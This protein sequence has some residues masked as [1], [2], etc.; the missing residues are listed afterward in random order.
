MTLLDF[1][2]SSFEKAWNK[3]P[4]GHAMIPERVERYDSQSSL[5]YAP[6][7]YKYKELAPS[8]DD[9]PDNVWIAENFMSFVRGEFGTLHNRGEC[10]PNPKL[11]TSNSIFLNPHYKYI[12]RCENELINSDFLNTLFKDVPRDLYANLYVLLTSSLIGNKENL[13]YLGGEQLAQK[14]EPLMSQQLR[15]QFVFPGFPF[16]DQNIFRTSSDASHVDLSE[17]ASFIRLHVLA[18]AISRVYPSGADWIIISE[19]MAYASTLYVGNDEV[20]EY[21]KK[22]LSYRNALNIQNTVSI[23]D[24][25][26]MTRKIRSEEAG[27]E[28]FES[29]EKYIS[30][31]LRALISKDDQNILKTLRI[32]TRG[33]KWN[34]NIKYL[35]LSWED[36]W[37][38]LNSEF[39]DQVEERLKSIWRDVYYLATEA[40]IKYASFNLALRFHTVIE[41]ILPMTIRATINPKPGQIAVPKLGNTYPWNGV[42]V[43]TKRDFGSTSIETWPLYK[44]LRHNSNA[45]SYAL[46]KGQGPFF[47]SS[48]SLS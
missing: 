23:I 44:L 32:L 43:L 47:F 46:E 14:F 1:E 16:K 40:A 10:P 42:G 35:G 15:L 34:I 13:R 22:L 4:S 36:T 39:E 12:E 18:L 29:T 3:L 41:K 6:I 33:M 25:K 37:I 26:E 17:I 20:L 9:F 48:L 24:L 21:R 8:S 38:I 31:S 45:I 2:I 28:I 11:I 19:G 27:Y 30:K 5:L 7:E